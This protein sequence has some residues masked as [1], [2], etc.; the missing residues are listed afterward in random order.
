MI[1]VFLGKPGS[2][3]GTQAEL[4]SEKLGIP[5]ITTGKILRN[6][7]KGSNPLAEEVKEKIDKGELVPDNLIMKIL[8]ERLQ[9]EDCQEGYILDGFPRNSEQAEMFNNTFEENIDK[10]FYIEVS[11]EAI[12][13]RLSSR[14]E[15]PSCGRV[16]NLITNPP[17]DDET[18]DFCGDT[19]LTREDDK[20]DV[21]R[22]RLEIYNNQT[23][24]LID[25]YKQKD[26][27]IEIDGEKPIEK[28]FEEIMNFIKTSA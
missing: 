10:V 15:C 4:V 2:G 8:K 12:I 14:R 19:L 3:K 17:K 27:L 16:Y 13:K 24:E 22:K 26:L 1:L 18:C 6:I 25:Y 23:K 7:E 28:V 20:P 9:Q 21:I 5:V 11:D